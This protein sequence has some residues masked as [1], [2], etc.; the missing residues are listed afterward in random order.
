MKL[1]FKI[2]KGDKMIFD[3]LE[4]NDLPLSRDE[5]ERM[6]SELCHT[7]N[8][9]TPISLAPHF[10]SLVRFNI[11]EYLPRDFVES[12]EFDK[13]IVENVDRDER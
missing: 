1:W 2:M 8:L 10:L 6:L 12:V 5:Y 3:T 7:A 9:S 11:T 4:K 13:V